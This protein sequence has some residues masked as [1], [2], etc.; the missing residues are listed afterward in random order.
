MDYWFID[1][2]TPMKVSPTLVKSMVSSLN[3]SNANI[4]SDIV[5]HWLP[6]AASLTI[7]DPNQPINLL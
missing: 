4:K 1:K 5:S 7:M 3:V 6:I 2:D